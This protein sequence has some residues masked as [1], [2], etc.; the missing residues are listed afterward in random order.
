MLDLQTFF[1]L[2]MNSWAYIV[3]DIKHFPLALPKITN[4]KLTRTSKSPDERE[5]DFERRLRNWSLTV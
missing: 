2:S 3:S 4:K 1:H 5:E